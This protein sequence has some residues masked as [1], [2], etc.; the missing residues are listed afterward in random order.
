MQDVLWSLLVCKIIINPV[1]YQ[2][3][4]SELQQHFSHLWGTRLTGLVLEIC[5][6]NFHQAPYIPNCDFCEWL[7]VDEVLYH[8][9]YLVFSN[10]V[11]F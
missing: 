4:T 7:Q 1:L 3:I 9:S 5:Q 11:A 10:Y 6:Y 2:N 8:T